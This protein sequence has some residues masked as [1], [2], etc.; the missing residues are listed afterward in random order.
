MSKQSHNCRVNGIFTRPGHKM[1]T[2]S[3]KR[4]PC[5]I[6]P[7][8]P[9]AVFWYTAN[10][11][12]SAVNNESCFFYE[13]QLWTYNFGIHTGGTD[14]RFVYMWHEGIAAR[15]STEISSCLYR[16]LSTIYTHA[17]HLILYSES[18]GGQNRNIHLLCLYLH[19][20]GNPSLPFDVIDHKF[21]VPG[22]S[23]LPNDWDF[24]VIEQAKRRRQQIYTPSERYELVRLVCRTS[25]FTVVE[26]SSEDFVEIKE[27][28]KLI[29]NRKVDT[30]GRSVDWLSIRWIQVRKEAP[31]KFRFRRS[32]TNWRIGRKWIFAVKLKD[33][34]LT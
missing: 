17:T 7:S 9:F 13:R 31:L 15:G 14:E 26:M 19:I 6:K 4:V 2:I 34:Q 21:M 24:G 33:A 12:Y 8:C 22:R 25:P 10:P 11:A 3:W 23:Y 28:T 20:V 5:K 16:H 29:T 32:W 1:H 27:L 18:C 30:L